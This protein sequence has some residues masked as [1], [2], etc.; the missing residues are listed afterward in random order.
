[1]VQMMDRSAKMHCASGRKARK[2]R[3]TPKGTSF[4]PGEELTGEGAGWHLVP[5]KYLFLYSMQ[6]E[7]TKGQLLTRISNGNNTNN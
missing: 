3:Q 5:K 4:T 6:K 7:E 1:M 2:T